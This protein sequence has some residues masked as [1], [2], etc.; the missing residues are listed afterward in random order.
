M[1]R[2]FNMMAI[3]LCLGL[4]LT[5][6]IL[7]N[8]SFEEGLNHWKVQSLVGEL[9]WEVTESIKR[10]TGN[11]LAQEAKKM[12]VIESKTKSPFR[13]KVQ[14]SARLTKPIRFND[15]GV[16]YYFNEYNSDSNAFYNFR[17][18]LFNS[19]LDSMIFLMDYGT[20]RS[21]ILKEMQYRSIG[22]NTNNN[23]RWLTHNVDSVVF[24][25]EYLSGFDTLKL[26]G[27]FFFALDNVQITSKFSSLEKPK[28]SDLVKIFPN[29]FFDMLHFSNF[30]IGQ[31]LRFY[32]VDGALVKV[33]LLEHNPL[34]VSDLTP[35]IYI[36]E[37]FKNHEV[38]RKRLVR[39]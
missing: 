15:I 8:P 38:Y 31:E 22:I 35:G 28:R 16:R 3:F 30:E 18:K 5:A 27:D 2:L 21:R 39:Q 9:E 14:Q 11:L 13:F 26:N 24:E 34:D 17:L 37:Y 6:Q 1:I 23:G 32:G 7:S 33:A 36:L 29:P 12:L 4:N 19:E 25:I 20:N 10:G